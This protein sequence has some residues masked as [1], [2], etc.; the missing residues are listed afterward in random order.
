MRWEQEKRHTLRTFH[1]QGLTV[2]EAFHLQVADAEAEHR[3]LV[4]SS[5]DLL[6]EGQ[7][8]GELVQ[9]AVEAVAVAFGWVGLD[10]IGARLFGA[11]VKEKKKTTQC[12]CENFSWTEKRYEDDKQAEG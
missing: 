1:K 12:K 7:Q 5:P 11:G 6:G 4:Q 2:E 9:L 10:A 3:Q 8:A